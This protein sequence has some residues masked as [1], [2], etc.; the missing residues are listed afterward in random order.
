MGV[1]GSVIPGGWKG[2][3]R[4]KARNKVRIMEVKRRARRI[5]RHALF[6]LLLSLWI[7]LPEI[8]RYE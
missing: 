4:M 7:K 2:R 6:L 5:V 3:K 1:S 8:C